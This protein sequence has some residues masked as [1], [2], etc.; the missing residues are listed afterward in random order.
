MNFCY[1]SYQ[2]DKHCNSIEQYPTQCENC[3]S[4]NVDDN[5]TK[6]KINVK[7][8]DCGHHQEKEAGQ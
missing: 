7:C 6:Y 3:M 1:V 5:S 8:C 4:E 2:I